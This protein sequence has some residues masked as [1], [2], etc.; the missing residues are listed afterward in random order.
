[1]ARRYQDDKALEFAPGNPLERIGNGLDVPVG[2]EGIAGR[3]R[4]KGLAEK[5]AKFVS[6]S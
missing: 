5:A 6:S 3:H 1:M 4:G 2:F